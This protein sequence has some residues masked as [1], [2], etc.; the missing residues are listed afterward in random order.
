MDYV[1]YHLLVF[2]SVLDAV[3]ILGSLQVYDPDQRVEE[4]FAFDN[5]IFFCEDLRDYDPG[6]IKAIGFFSLILLFLSLL[7]P[8]LFP[9]LFSLFASLLV[10]LFLSNLT[11]LVFLNSLLLKPLLLKSH[12]LIKINDILEI[13]LA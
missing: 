12:M 8:I 6:Y 5:V 10:Q 4:F 2:L 11:F 13:L 1:T 9:L 7:F 3:L